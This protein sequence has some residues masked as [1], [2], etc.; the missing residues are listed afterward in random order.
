MTAPAP[1]AAI[2]APTGQLPAAAVANAPSSDNTPPPMS[3]DAAGDA[4]ASQTTIASR[5]P[6]QLNAGG[7]DDSAQA[8]DS[9]SMN[10]QLD[11]ASAP[12]P[13]A[14]ASVPLATAD[15]P[16]SAG[17]QPGSMQ[18]LLTIMIAALALSA[19]AG[20]AILR[21]RRRKGEEDEAELD[22]DRRPVWD[23]EYVDRPLPYPAAAAHRPNIGRPRELR[24]VEPDD[25]I[26][27]MLAR[28]ARSAQT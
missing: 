6:D 16:P 18:G 14:A 27:E 2:A 23:R 8:A 9:S 26:K 3:T 17:K 25:T 19:L 15:A 11:T 24:S 22:L 10:A 4:D 5:W 1:A 7:S 13:P 28:L 21:L 12:P 20:G